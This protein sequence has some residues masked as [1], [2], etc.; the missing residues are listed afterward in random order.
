MYNKISND[1]QLDTK[2][3]IGNK[4]AG[5]FINTS[6]SFII[7][8]VKPII[9]NFLLPLITGEIIITDTLFEVKK[10]DSDTATKTKEQKSNSTKNMNKNFS[11][12]ITEMLVNQNEPISTDKPEST[13]IKILKLFKTNKIDIKNLSTCIE[14]LIYSFRKYVEVL[15]NN[16]PTPKLNDKSDIKLSKYYSK[17]LFK[18]MKQNTTSRLA[19]N[20]AKTKIKNNIL[21]SMGFP[22]N[23]ENTENSTDV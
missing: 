21:L 4:L 22:I 18:L 20:A 16:L 8:M 7:S 12:R 9:D 11:K 3:K 1:E 17:L 23:I 14:G 13:Y 2:K 15:R 5:S 6:A 10:V 19:Y